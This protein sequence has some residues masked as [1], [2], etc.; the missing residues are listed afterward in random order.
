MASEVLLINTNISRPPVSPVGMEYVA[1]ALTGSGICVR[2]LDLSFEKDWAGAI[3]KEIKNC[4]PVAVGLAVRNTDDCSFSTRKSFLPWICDVVRKVRSFTEAHVIL[5][6]GGFSVMPEAILGMTR[7]DFGISG[8]GEEAM[9]ELVGCLLNN[10]N[11]STIPGLVYWRGDKP[12]SNPV[13][14]ADLKLLPAPERKFFNNRRYQE[15]GAIVGIETKRGC[16]QECIYCA[17][18]VIKGNKIR[19]RPP[20]KVVLE[21]KNLISQGV[22]WLHL[23]DSEFNLPIEHAK[24]VCRAIIRAGLGDKLKWYTYCCP[25]SFDTELAGLMKRA[26]CSGINFGVDSLHDEQLKRLG[27]N[28]TTEDVKQLVKILKG[29]GF[30]YMFDFLAGGPG[31]TRDTVKA[32]ISGIK[33]LDVP[34]SGIAAGVRVYPGTP[35]SK[36][37]ACKDRQELYHKGGK[38]THCPEFYISPHLGDEAADIVSSLING[39]P[40]FVFLSPRAEQA[41]YNY[42][43]SEDLCRVIKNGARGA[44]WDII[45]RKSC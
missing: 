29:H 16:Y 14:Y 20:E 12:A 6:G 30:K 23:C 42:A 4:E 7:A 8:D 31:E 15:E 45:N 18:P 28:H 24:E 10:K 2:V 41:S 34:L 19:M 32:T 39:D 1:E 40:R 27:R 38:W 5:G 43:D 11:V 37:A 33:E 36:D 44:Y 21:F 26:G 9:P 3:E 13:N 22:S 35:L 25:V 17:D